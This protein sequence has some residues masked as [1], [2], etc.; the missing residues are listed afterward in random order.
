MTPDVLEQSTVDRESS[1]V[2]A[3]QQHQPVSRRRRLTWII[4]LVV[5][6]L[7][8]A[9]LIHHRIA[10]QGKQQHFG[11]GAMMNGP[12]PVGVGKVGTA[13]VPVV[14]EALGT[15]TPLATV[16]IRPQVTGSL[17]KIDFPEGEIV[18]AG[19]VLAQ[20]DPRPY[21]AALD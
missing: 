21:Q 2:S 1:S 16:Q 4:G 18:K 9:W 14:L 8:L 11:R 17:V 19:G 7:G 13:D 5:L 10:S 6:V 20:I 15:V 12:M 3:P